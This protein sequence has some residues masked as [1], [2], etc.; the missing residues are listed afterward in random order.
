MN[1]RRLFLTTSLL[2]LVCIFFSAGAPRSIQA[3]EN[4]PPTPEDARTGAWL[5]TIHIRTMPNDSGVIDELQAGNLDMYATESIDPDL[6]DIV[7]GDPDLE[8]FTDYGLYYELTLNPAGPVFSGNGKL[9]P[10]AVPKIREALNWLVDRKHLVEHIYGGM[11]VSKYVVT[12]TGFPDF[13]RYKDTI[14]DIET[15]Y[16]YDFDQAKTVISNEMLTLGAYQVSGKWYFNGQPVVLIILI[17]TDS[18]GTRVPMG[19]Y[20][21]DQLEDIGFTVT[22]QFG[23]YSELAPIWVLGD[24]ND[25]LWHLYTGAWGTGRI[26]RDEGDSFQFLYSPDSTYGFSPLWQAYDITPEFR[27][28]ANKLAAKDYASRGKRD[29]LFNDALLMSM[30]ESLRIWLVYGKGYLPRR[31]ETTLAYDLIVGLYNDLWPY[32]ARFI[33]QEGGTMEITQVDQFIDPWNP[34]DGS[35]WS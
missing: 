10:F 8:A 19:N 28:I 20:V 13:S 34:I 9:N 11:G 29:Q 25:G 3:H 23:T 22:R 5:D 16:H 27:E 30:E 26:P 15:Y 2:I 31:A 33:G 12:G 14:Q 7:Q 24:P 32:T 17:R 1:T 18:D 4:P 21:A 6:F 35:N